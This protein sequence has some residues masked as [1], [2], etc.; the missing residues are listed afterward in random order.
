MQPKVRN[1]LGELGYDV[2]KP[3]THFASI[4]IS[5]YDGKTSVVEGVYLTLPEDMPVAFILSD[6]KYYIRGLEQEL[7]KLEN[8]NEDTA[9]QGIVNV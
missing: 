1:K 2:I 3:P 7:E 4:K 5:T 8:I 6:M 9:K